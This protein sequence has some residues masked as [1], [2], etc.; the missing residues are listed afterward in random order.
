[1][2]DNMAIVNVVFSTQS[3]S[4]YTVLKCG[5]TYEK[6]SLQMLLGTSYKLVKRNECVDLF[7]KMVLQKYLSL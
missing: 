2:F 7:S 6:Y 3:D 4:K 1:M 5:R